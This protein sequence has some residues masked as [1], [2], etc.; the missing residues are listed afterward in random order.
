MRQDESSRVCTLFWTKNSRTFKDTFLIF[1][2]CL[3]RCNN[4]FYLLSTILCLL[5]TFMPVTLYFQIRHLKI[6]V[7]QLKLATNFK[8]FPTATS[9][10]KDF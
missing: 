6:W 4:L 2:G 3:V 8:D 9:I 7:G 5:T 10:F 1:Q